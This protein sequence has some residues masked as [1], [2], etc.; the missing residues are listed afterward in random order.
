MT[1]VL[2]AGLVSGDYAADEVVGYEEKWHSTI[3][4]EQ[5]ATCNEALL[6][7]VAAVKTGTERASCQLFKNRKLFPS[8]NLRA[9]DQA[10]DI[11]HEPCG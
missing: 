8:S 4:D 3:R 11:F 9:P 1:L 2:P 7:A 6:R 5:R 10:C